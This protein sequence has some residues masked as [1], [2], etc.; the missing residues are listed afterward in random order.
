MK[1]QNSAGVIRVLLAVSLAILIVASLPSPEAFAGSEVPEKALVGPELAVG[2]CTEA[3]KID[4]VLDDEAWK[5][6]AQCA[7][8]DTNTAKQPLEKTD[9]RITYDK[10]YLYLA[11]QCYESQMDKVVA[12][13][14][15]RN[16][17]EIWKDDCIEVFLAPPIAPSS[18]TTVYFH[19]LMNSNGAFYAGSPY[20][21][22]DWDPD[23]R[24][25][26][27]RWG[28]RW[29][30]EVAIDFKSLG[31][32]SPLPGEIW[33]ANLCREQKTHG[34][35]LLSCF[36]PVGPHFHKPLFFG[37]F[38]FTE[39]PEA[40]GDG[41]LTGT[42]THENASL[43]GAR[44]VL[45]KQFTKTDEAG[46]FR[47]EKIPA[48][49]QVLHITKE[50][51]V[52]V[53]QRIEV[54]KCLVMEEPL[55]LIA[56][57]PYGFDFPVETLAPDKP[58]Q[59]Y[60]NHVN[61]PMKPGKHP[62]QELIAAKRNMTLKTSATLGSFEPMTF[63][64]FT[65]EELQ[66]CRLEISDLVC[67]DDPSERIPSTLAE[68]R[69]V[70]V[71]IPPASMGGDLDIRNV[72]YRPEILDP[73]TTVDMPAKTFRQYWITW[74]IP[75]GTKAGTYRGQIAFQPE[76][77][78]KTVLH[79]EMMVF[80]FA[81]EKSKNKL[82]GMYYHGGHTSS[83]F[84]F[85]VNRHKK[86]K[87]F[88][89]D[90]IDMRQHGVEGGITCTS[91]PRFTREAGEVVIDYA[92]VEYVLDL[93]KDLGWNDAI[94]VMD[95][96]TISID[97]GYATRL[98][99]EQSNTYDFSEE[100]VSVLKETIQG[101]NDRFRQRGL[102]QPYYMWL[103]EIT[104]F[105]EEEV[106]KWVKMGKIFREISGNSKSF[107]T[108]ED[109]APKKYWDKIA[110]YLDVPVCTETNYIPKLQKAYPSIQIWAKYGDT[111]P[112]SG[113]FKANRVDKGFGFYFSPISQ[114]WQ[115]AHQA[116]VT[117]QDKENAPRYP[118]LTFTVP[119]EDGSPI[120][121][122]QWEGYREG[123]KD[124]GYL[125]TLENEIARREAMFGKSEVVAEAK[126]LHKTITDE[127]RSIGTKQQEAEN[128]RSVNLMRLDNR[129][130]DAMRR[131]IGNMI[132]RL[133]A[134]R[135]KQGEKTE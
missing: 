59:I 93:V 80:P 56:A 130:F 20:S 17:P 50:A 7:F 106:N 77:K 108:L 88:R 114:N 89:A 32:S 66:G 104:Q 102:P 70:R 96:G 21:G 11:F 107:V 6:A 42:V 35:N 1:G 69:A 37:S 15:E 127:L 49:S 10:E 85:H 118:W 22:I 60:L 97:A 117:G 109:G 45:G 134:E 46:R 111:G 25:S 9:A 47:L 123:T 23:I 95:L 125:I 132:R 33:R 12:V 39:T 3:P 113:A 44:V 115:W 55:D 24:V 131:D 79:V 4:G 54:D 30:L 91:R 8:L 116:I 34:T 99:P 110:P 133:T 52:S 83:W 28:D 75:E 82:Y 43:A 81:L 72:G 26:A 119:A 38:Q 121:T 120:P 58:Y 62:S 68:S 90:F 101:L 16:I 63:T 67:L 18:P 98:T 29:T 126:E 64:V 71:W 41:S 87:D 112:R 78:E 51:F 48:G 100:H 124:L 27:K 40:D 5:N 73:L 122:L 94:L 92:P 57:T 128:V 84:S 19:L 2:K 74:H 13:Q 103:D 129:R 65:K 76:N 36:S 53:I 86:E 14:T 61:S 31:R 135:K 105:G